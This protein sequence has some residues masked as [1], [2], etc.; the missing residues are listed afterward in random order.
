MRKRKSVAKKVRSKTVA[1]KARLKGLPRNRG[2]KLLERGHTIRRRVACGRAVGA[3]ER[4]EARAA[5]HQAAGMTS[6]SSNPSSLQLAGLMIGRGQRGS[7]IPLLPGTIF[8]ILS[9]FAEQVLPDYAYRGENYA[10]NTCPARYSR[11]SQRFRLLLRLDLALLHQPIFDVAAC[12]V[13]TLEAAD[14]CTWASTVLYSLKR[15]FMAPWASSSFRCSS[16]NMC[17]FLPL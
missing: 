16:V 11:P 8:G 1:R 10:D 3:Q 17:K 2:P 12:D 14:G 9:L 7:P 5:E 4:L 6:H 15:M 13:T